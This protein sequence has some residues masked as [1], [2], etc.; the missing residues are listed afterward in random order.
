[1]ITMTLFVSIKFLALC[2]K[3]PSFLVNSSKKVLLHQGK[4]EGKCQFNRDLQAMNRKL[5][6]AFT[7]C[8]FISLVFLLLTLLLYKTLP[9]LQN[10]QGNIIC[11]YISSIILTTILLVI[12]YNAKLQVP[13]PYSSISFCGNCFT[14]LNI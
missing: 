12:H 9:E 5:R 11:G 13:V 10:F 2:A 6:L 3:R 7:I 4:D 8:G 14:S 1:M